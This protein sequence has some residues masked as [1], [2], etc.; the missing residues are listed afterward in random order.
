MKN[1]KPCEKC[2]D[3]GT[4]EC[5]TISETYEDGWLI[6]TDYKCK[7]CGRIVFEDIE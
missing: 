2:K 4:K 1:Q 3:L 7:N 6:R 5:E